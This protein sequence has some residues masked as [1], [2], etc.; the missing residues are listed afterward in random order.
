L[1]LVIWFNSIGDFYYDNWL[2]RAIRRR[3]MEILTHSPFTLLVV[4]IILIVVSTRFVGLLM[5]RIG[6]PQVI[7]EVIG[8]VLLGP[9]LLGW[10]LP[11]FSQALFTPPSLQLLNMVSQLG[12]VLFI[13]LIGLELDPKLMRGNGYTSIVISYS[14]II[15]PFAL[16]VPLAIYLYPRLAPSGVPYSSF[17]LFIG[18][19]MSITAFPVLARILSER[20]LTDTPIGALT[21]TVAAVDDVTAWCLLAFVVSIVNSS[22]MSEAVVTTILAFTYIATMWWVVKPFMRRFG[23]RSANREGLTQNNV[24]ITLILLLISSLTTEIIGIHALFG[25][26]MFGVIMPRE[27]NFVQ[28][29]AEKIEDLVLVLLLPLF[30]AYSGLRTEIGLLTGLSDWLM[31]GLIILVA[32]LGKFGGCFVSARLMGISWRDSAAMGILVNTRGLMELVVLNI[33]L[34]LKVISPELFAMMVIM[35]LVTTFITTPLL[36]L[37]YSREQL[38]ALRVEEA[39]PKM[40]VARQFTILMC[41][42]Y[43]RSGP[44]L[45]RM[46][47]ALTATIPGQSR[48]YALRLLPVTDRAS[49]YVEATHEEHGATVLSPLL[50]EAQANGREVNPLAFISPSPDSDICDVAHT[51]QADLILLGWHKPLISDTI[52]GGTVGSVMRQATADVGVLVDRGLMNIRKVLVVY[53]TGSVHDQATLK[54]AQRIRNNAN[55]EMT[56]LQVITPGSAAETALDL[57]PTFLE[58]AADSA[59]AYFKKITETDPSLAIVQECGQGYD[60]VIIGLGAEWGLAERTFGFR[61]EYVVQHT[62]IS[63][64]IMHGI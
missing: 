15:V 37:I 61:Q 17:I 38:L 49:F 10:L 59:P 51:K 19:S 20:R 30:F 31:C 6:Q 23:A 41:V 28:V 8:G 3:F 29:L 1:F 50:R 43:D 58:I 25:A 55:I 63:L 24:A 2:F 4:Q 57:K 26:F 39:D 18:I 56:I 13:F 48:L 36:S 44:G 5:R 33:G 32:C 7:A 62:D 35:A 64:L 21:I 46:A 60:L 53:G 40:S 22:A 14:S 11:T 52:L 9:S 54:V 16:G 47:H 42:A 12:L 45:F 27:G 34:D